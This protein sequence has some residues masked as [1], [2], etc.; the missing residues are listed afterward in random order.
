[1]WGVLMTERVD[2]QQAVTTMLTTQ[3]QQREKD[4][5]DEPF[6]LCRD[7]G[8]INASSDG[9]DESQLDIMA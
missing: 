9:G 5:G 8:A 3:Q 7:G 4:V 6:C 1:M 2:G